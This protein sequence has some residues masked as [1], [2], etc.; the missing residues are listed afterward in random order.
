MT[1]ATMIVATSTLLAVA[2]L[3][4]NA[5][6]RIAPIPGFL[7]TERTEERIAGRFTHGAYVGVFE[8][9][10]ESSSL[11]SAQ[12]R[13]GLPAGV[14]E[15]GREAER[16]LVLDASAQFSEGG[17]KTSVIIDGLFS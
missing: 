13:V 17:E 7:I 5:Q 8:A 12:V 15:P 1:I 10:K 16:E 9:N 3:A 11:A 4:T 6:R 14:T 2:A